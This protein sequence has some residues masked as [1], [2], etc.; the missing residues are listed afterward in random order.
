M[1]VANAIEVTLRD[2]SILLVS[3]F[4]FE[5]FLLLVFFVHTLTCNLSSCCCRCHR[6]CC[7]RCHRL[8][9]SLS[10]TLLC[11]CHRRCCCRCHRRCCAK[12]SSSNGTVKITAGA[13]GPLIAG[14]AYG[15]FR[16]CRW[17][18]WLF[19]L[20][21]LNLKSFFFLLKNCFIHVQRLNFLS[22]FK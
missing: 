9:L 6:R 7:C 21:Y 20:P 8:L 11:R 12:I 15:K 19:V 10:S 18:V 14:D 3:F 13:L 22:L 5:L 2:E 16:C 1:M 17:N 4:N